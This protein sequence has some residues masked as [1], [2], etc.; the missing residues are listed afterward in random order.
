MPLLG[1]IKVNT[2]RVAQGT[3]AIG[4][5][6]LFRNCRAFIKGFFAKPLPIR[7]AFEM[8]IHVIIAANDHAWKKEWHL[9]WIEADLSIL[10]S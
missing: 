10:F 2:D 5:G 1:W 7:F 6:G 3:L 4:C 9:L 8:E